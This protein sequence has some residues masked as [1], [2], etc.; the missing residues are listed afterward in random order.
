MISDKWAVS[1]KAWGKRACHGVTVAVVAAVA[2]TITAVVPMTTSPVRA[3]EVKL[4]TPCEALNQ[5]DI[6]KVD[7]PQCR[8]VRAI[9]FDENGNMLFAERLQ[10]VSGRLVRITKVCDPDVDA[11][12]PGGCLPKCLLCMGT[13]R[14]CNCLC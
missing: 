1:F 11:D 2:A 5:F 7:N 12:C 6:T 8:A 10:S 4:E 9:Y 14:K 3:A 13:P